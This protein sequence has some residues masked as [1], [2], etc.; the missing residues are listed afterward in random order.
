LESFSYSVSH[1][2]RAPLRAI[3]GF[4]RIILK[5]QGEKFD[6][7]TRKQ[8]NTIQQKAGDMDRLITDLL[9]LSR[10]DRQT[11][12]LQ[13][14]DMQQLIEE[15]WRELQ[16]V[17]PG[18]S[19]TLKAGPMPSASADKGLV[20]QVIVNLL[21]NAMKFTGTRE[22]ALIEG[23]GYGNDKET[24]YYVRDNGVGFDM[25]YY[26]KLFSVFQRLHSESEYEGTGI[27]LAIVQ[28][29]VHRHGGRVWAEGKVNEG[30]VFYFSLPS[31]ETKMPDA[32][33]ALEV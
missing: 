2:L 20:R 4:T 25:Q 26:D 15:T 29:I 33:S 10:L 31:R 9:A 27:G 18:R 28:R 6:E 7:E 19:M 5:R 14:F 11:L 13:T 22:T 32:N 1:D 3:Q 21:S 23:G 16:G 30:A 12:N 24:V 8:F 17:Y